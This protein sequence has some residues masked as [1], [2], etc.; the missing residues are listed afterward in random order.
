MERKKKRGVNPR[1]KLLVENKSFRC[2]DR[3][4]AKNEKGPKWCWGKWQFMGWG[5]GPEAKKKERTKRELRG[6]GGRGVV[7]CWWGNVEKKRKS[8]QLGRLKC[9]TH[10]ICVNLPAYQNKKEEKN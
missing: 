10:Y 3:R 9:V 8:H 2:T 7:P 4:E 6:K 1:I 5:W